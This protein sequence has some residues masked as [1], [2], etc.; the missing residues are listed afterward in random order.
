[1][2][3]TFSKSLLKPLISVLFIAK[4]K[5]EILHKK[6]N[7]KSYNKTVIDFNEVDIRIYQPE[8]VI[9]TETGLI[10]IRIYQPFIPFSGLDEYHFFS[11]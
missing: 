8:K 7:T 9:Y 10:D 2:T 4:V 6:S 5:V 11:G 1:M 3:K